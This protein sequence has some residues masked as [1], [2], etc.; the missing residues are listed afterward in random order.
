MP[1]E[2]CRIC[3]G[4]LTKRTLCAECKKATSMICVNCGKQTLEQSHENCI[5]MIKVYY[6]NNF[7]GPLRKQRNFL[8]LA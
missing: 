4:S 3:G 2:S 6:K 5:S 7:A 1:D 8:S